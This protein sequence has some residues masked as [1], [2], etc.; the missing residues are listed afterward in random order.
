MS[1]DFESLII[2]RTAAKLITL[3]PN[4]FGRFAIT[5]FSQYIEQV[6]LKINPFEALVEPYMKGLI[7][8]L[9]PKKVGI[10]L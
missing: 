9:K 4:A 6:A 10:N 1:F 8:H 5:Q 3:L 7:F 2:E